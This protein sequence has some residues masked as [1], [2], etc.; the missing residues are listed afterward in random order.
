LKLFI[1]IVNC[2]E[3]ELTLKIIVFLTAKTQGKYAKNAK[4]KVI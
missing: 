4:N 1:L 3:C 2:K